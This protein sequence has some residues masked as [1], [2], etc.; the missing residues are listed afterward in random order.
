MFP[1]C[2][3]GPAIFISIFP[4]FECKDSKTT[5]IHRFAHPQWKNALC[6]LLK[7]VVLVTP[8]CEFCTERG[9][10]ELWT[11]NPPQPII[12]RSGK[13]EVQVTSRSRL[14]CDMDWN[15][16]DICTIISS[17]WL[18]LMKSKY[19]FSNP[20]VRGNA[21]YEHHSTTGASHKCQEADRGCSICHVGKVDFTW[22]HSVSHPLP[23]PFATSL[24]SIC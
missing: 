18:L 4:R 10:L 6:P 8:Q 20:L 22:R 7:R 2:C 5:L 24:S 11:V 9:G 1:L 21:W 12:G 19:Y 17:Y 13:P 15:Y 23:T 14:L 16:Y 3:C